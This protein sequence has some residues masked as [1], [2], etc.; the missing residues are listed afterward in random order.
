MGELHNCVRRDCKQRF[1][2]DGQ[3]LCPRHRVY[4]GD[5][6]SCDSL[7][8]ELAALRIEYS[9]RQ[10]EIAA[11]KAK[12]RE[13]AARL[14]EKREALADQFGN[15]GDSYREGKADAYDAASW[16]LRELGLI[17]GDDA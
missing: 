16:W 6:P 10:N 2:F 12:V 15:Y 14:N 1:E 4:P 5:C 9:G 17:G 7:R 13:L 11:Y 3:I 8:A